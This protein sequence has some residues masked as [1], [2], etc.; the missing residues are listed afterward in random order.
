MSIKHS[1][2]SESDKNWKQKM[3]KQRDNFIKS[4]R[5]TDRDT[6]DSL[7]RKTI[8]D[9]KDLEYLF[10][11]SGRYQIGTDYFLEKGIDKKIVDYFTER[12]LG[13]EDTRFMGYDDKTKTQR[14]LSDVE[15]VDGITFWNFYI[16]IVRSLGLKTKE[17]FHRSEISNEHRDTIRKYLKLKKESNSSRR[18]RLRMEKNKR[19]K[20]MKETYK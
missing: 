10:D 11:W 2:V 8:H 17:R 1:G 16:E 6:I 13:F 20:T 14:F 7:V 12:I 18:I 5:E 9:W 3:I 4:N 19:K 15:Y